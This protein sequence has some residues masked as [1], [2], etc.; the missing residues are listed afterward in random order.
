MRHMRHDDQ[1]AS[2]EDIA[3]GASSIK[4]AD[5]P[6]RP[7]YPGEA[8]TTESPPDE[9]AGHPTGGAAE[10]DIP[11]GEGRRKAEGEGEESLLPPD[12]A[13][14]LRDRWRQVQTRFVDDPR[15]AVSSADE[16]VADL[17]RRLAENFAGRKRTLENQWNRDGKA[18]TEELRVTLQQ[19]RVFFDRLLST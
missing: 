12:D 6:E 18:D 1:R 2:T 13:D 10:G 16:L 3:A 15:E 8:T 19:Y 4:E 7:V 11:D 5:T 9:T 14:E 17:M